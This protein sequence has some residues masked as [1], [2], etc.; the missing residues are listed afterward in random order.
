MPRTI[1]ALLAAF[2]LWPLAAA[3]TEAEL[4]QLSRDVAAAEVRGDAAYLDG[5]WAP[6]FTVTSQFG[7][8]SSKAEQLA[9]VRSGANRFDSIEVR[10][11]RAR[12]YGDAG[13]VSEVLVLKGQVAGRPVEGTVR[14]LTVWVRKDGRWQAVATQYT[15]VQVAP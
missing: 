6:E 10:D 8:V 5:A 12:V 4:V 14:A 3:A 13:M 1:A 9:I 11:A 7:Q 2:A 15:R